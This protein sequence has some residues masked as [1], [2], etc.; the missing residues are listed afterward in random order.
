MRNQPAD[1]PETVDHVNSGIDASALMKS[2][3]LILV[4]VQLQMLEHGQFPRRR[5][6]AA[7]ALFLPD[8]T[9]LML[10]DDIRYFRDG[11]V[12]PRKSAA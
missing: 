11:L 4:P 3:L 12:S 1:R 6:L 10:G 8:L 7:E 5:V 2:V 9:V